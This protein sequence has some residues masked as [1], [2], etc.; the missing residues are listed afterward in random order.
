MKDRFEKIRQITEKEL[1]FS[2]HDMEHVMRVY[3]M[4]MK[5]AK[6]EK[7]VDHEILKAAV[8]L[9]DIARSREDDDKTGKICHSKESAKRSKTILEKMG[10]SAEKI[11]KIQH[12]IL[13]HRF[14]TYKKPRII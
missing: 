6:T 12:C 10:F 7:N 13:A 9:H 14:T 2:A 3:R 5:I 4:A 8:L 11:K 1:A